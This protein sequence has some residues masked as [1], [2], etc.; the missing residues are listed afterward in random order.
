MNESFH[1]SATKIEANI[2]INFLD[3]MSRFYPQR[4]RKRKENERIAAFARSVGLLSGPA[5][6]SGKQTALRIDRRKRVKG[7]KERSC[8]VK[9]VQR[10]RNFASVLNY[11]WSQWAPGSMET[12][13]EVTGSLAVHGTYSYDQIYLAPRRDQAPRTFLSIPNFPN[14]KIVAASSSSARK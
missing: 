6:Y 10:A 5:Q 4:S 2:A 9:Q 13:V 7:F 12:L 11:G 1:P 14:C 8:C 3:M